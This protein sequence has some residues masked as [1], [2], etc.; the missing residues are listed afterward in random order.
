MDYLKMNIHETF[1]IKIIYYNIKLFK[2]KRDI[3]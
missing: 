1:E 2:A 3:W